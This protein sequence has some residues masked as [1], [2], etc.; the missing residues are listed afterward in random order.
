MYNCT[1]IYVERC[2][3][4]PGL[5]GARYPWESALTGAEVCPAVAQDVRDQEVAQ[6]SPIT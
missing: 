1:Y 5:P 4:S 6:F 2:F 3:W